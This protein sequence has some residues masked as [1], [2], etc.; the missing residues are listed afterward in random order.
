[1]GICPLLN[2]I[3]LY[4]ILV[5]VWIVDASQICDIN[6]AHAACVMAIKEVM[7]DSTLVLVFYLPY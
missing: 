5:L 2:I 3:L 6:T 4:D 7:M 1:M